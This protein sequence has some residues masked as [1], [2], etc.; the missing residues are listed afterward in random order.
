MPAKGEPAN[1]L[2]LAVLAGPHA[3]RPQYEPTPADRATV[4]NLAACGV[5]HVE[6]ARCLGTEG[7]DPHTLYKY[8][9]EELDT[10]LTKVKALAMS[11]V[12]MAMQAGEPWAVCFFLKCRAGWRERSEVELSGT[13]EMNVNGAEQLKARIDSLIARNREADATSIP[14]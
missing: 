5:S 3:R 1:A 6:I 9:R 11:K 4:Q 14:Q 8:F 2:Q 7:I 13:V 10:S 12:V